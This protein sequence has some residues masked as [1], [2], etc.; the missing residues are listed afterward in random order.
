MDPNDQVG[1][2][3][4]LS[5]HIPLCIS[6]VVGMNV[7]PFT[8]SR[9]SVFSF[10]ITNTI[11]MPSLG[12]YWSD[13]TIGTVARVSALSLWIYSPMLQ[14]KSRVDNVLVLCDELYNH[15]SFLLLCPPSETE[16]HDMSR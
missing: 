15:T 12:I 2:D 6:S 16:E 5:V 10:L 7:T 14:K 3:L 4:L 11:V 9:C 13:H 8:K 1:S